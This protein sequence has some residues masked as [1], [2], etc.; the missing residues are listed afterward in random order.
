[1]KLNHLHIAVPDV[2]KA[3][4]FY[5][6]FFNFKVAFEHGTCLFLK[7]DVGFLLAIDPLEKN[8]K[9]NF[10]SWYHFGFC[11]DSAAKVKELYSRM[12]DSGVEFAR[13]YKEFG[14][15]GANFLCWSPGPFKMEVSWNK[16]E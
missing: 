6:T 7:D 14:D 1:M 15:A 5:E 13:D 2:K 10:P 12:K 8:E 9:V 16:D 3:Q 4:H 11:V